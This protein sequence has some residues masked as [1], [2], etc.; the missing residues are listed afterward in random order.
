LRTFSQGFPVHSHHAS[1]G[2]R[3]AGTYR[4]MPLMPGRTGALSLMIGLVLDGSGS[5]IGVLYPDLRRDREQNDPC[6]LAFALALPRR[7]SS[8]RPSLRGTVDSAAATGTFPPGRHCMRRAAI[9]GW[10]LV[11]PH[12]ANI[13][14]FER[15]LD[16]A[17]SWLTPFNGFGPD[18]FLV[19]NPKFDFAA[20]QP[21][22]EERFPPSRFRQLTDKMDP[23]SLY[24]IG[25]FIQSLGQNPG[26][27]RALMEL[28]PQAHV[29]VGNALGAYPTVCR[30][31]IEFHRAQRR[32]NRFWAAPE[33]T[34][35]LREYVAH[36]GDVPVRDPATFEDPDER[37]A[38]EDAWFGYWSERSEKLRE[39]LAELREIEGQRVEG[40]VESGKLKVIRDKRRRLAQMME[41]WQT[42]EPP[43]NQV[44]A[45]LLWNIPNTPASQISMLGRITGFTFAPIAACSTFGVGLKL[46]LDA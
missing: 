10:G 24:G 21:W 45:N 41:K 9:Y 31:A 16:G 44:S 33:R 5:G 2:T 30:T 6:E 18:N 8:S 27:E 11:A 4:L 40:D 12:S 38:A 1:R 26:L 32:W 39:Y 23:T 37:E 19:G 3:R 20:Y 25:A 29:Y 43:W 34:A 46:A 28:G 36:G 22:I 42:P 15:N 35:A 7:R 17:E 14:E 13:D